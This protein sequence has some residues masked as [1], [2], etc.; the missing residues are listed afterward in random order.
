MNKL[1]LIILLLFSLISVGC[2]PIFLKEDQPII[3]DNS[4]GLSEN[5]TL[6]QGEKYEEDQFIINKI[7]SNFAEGLLYDISDDGEL[8]LIK[9]PTNTISGDLKSPENYSNLYTY[10]VKNQQQKQILTS[11]KEQSYA[12]FEKANKG[13][14]YVEYSKDSN[15]Q[16]IPNSY[17]LNWTDYEGSQT[18]RISS[19]DESVSQKFSLID[20]NLIVYGNSNGQIHLVK[21]KDIVRATI[22]R[23]TYT[24]NKKL[25][26]YKINYVPEYKLAFFLATNPATNV[27]DLYYVLLDEKNVEP[28]L[29]QDNVTDFTLSNRDKSVLYSVGTKS[30]TQL[31]NVD[32]YYNK[33][34]IYEGPLAGFSY[35]PDQSHIVY[36][37][38]IDDSSNNQNLWIMN[39]DGSN[40]TQLASNLKI[41][42][43][44]VI[45]SPDMHSVYFSVL[46]LKESSEKNNESIL[47]HN[48]Y[49]IDY[50]Y[51][52][53]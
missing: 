34:I 50:S 53:K 7:N 29:M 46:S 22:P 28:V 21:T 5:Q 25:N 38:K 43:D 2:S 4:T 13:I 48:L 20:N 24:L 35:S 11:S 52:K 1:K 12:V 17:K 30:Q 42:S 31:V 26:I 37:E 45:F 40:S 3:L 10:N 51:T 49:S 39:A 6:I 41:C 16:I 27:M 9:I 47:K 14:L 18:K 23:E 33:N 32:L 19:S 44:R 15:E 8:L 36:R